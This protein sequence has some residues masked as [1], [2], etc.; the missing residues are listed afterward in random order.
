ME[1]KMEELKSLLTN[2]KEEKNTAFTYR[3]LSSEEKDIHLSEIYKRMAEIEEIHAAHFEDEIRKKGSVVPEFSPDFRT[4]IL[5]WISK[6]FGPTSVLPGMQ[7]KEQ[8]GINTYLKAGGNRKYAGDE[9]L[10]ARMLSQISSVSSGGMSGNTLAQLEGRH[11][12]TG[13]NALRAAVLGANDGMVSNLSLVMGVAGVSMNNSAILIAGMA[14]LLAGAISMALGEWLSVQ[15]SRELYTNQIKIEQAEVEQSPE[16]ETEELSLIYQSRGLG[17]DQANQ[18]A[19]QILSNKDYALG[20]LAREELGINPEELGGSAWEAA[21]T[22]FL[23]FALGAI[24]PLFPYFFLS[25]IHAVIISIC[26]SI[27]GLFVLGS[28]I[29]LFTGKAIL[30]SGFR[31]V[32]FGMAAAGVTFGIGRL[33]GRSLGG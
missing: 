8:Q 1:E 2:W 20:T 10:H 17:K 19:K 6:K 9:Q 14:G 22:S 31:M 30:Y 12:A 33:I 16:E 21:I 29:T 3:S 25:G 7:S 26:A 11:R 18:M 24:V 5:V 27:V 4:K 15:S 28:V 13:G 32:A 23:L